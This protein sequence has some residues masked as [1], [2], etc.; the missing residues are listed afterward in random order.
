MQRFI[1]TSSV[2][3]R[4]VFNTEDQFRTDTYYPVIDS[5]L[6]EL[7]DH[8]SGQHMENLS[9]ISALCPD[10]KNFLDIDVLQISLSHMKC[11]SS[12]LFN[13]VLAEKLC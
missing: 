7:I 5:I 6:I 3:Q 12:P 9:S 10:H 13:E 2:G 11:V 1:N 8:F 4:D